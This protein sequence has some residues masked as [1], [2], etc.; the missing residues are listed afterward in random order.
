MHQHGLTDV[1]L[2]S[3]CHG[4]GYLTHINLYHY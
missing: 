4:V 3:N 2:F 1:L